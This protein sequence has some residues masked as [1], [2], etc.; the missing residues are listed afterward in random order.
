MEYR[1]S[2]ETDTYEGVLDF[3][4]NS[5]PFGTGRAVLDAAQRALRGIG[6]TP[7]RSCAR[8]RSVLSGEL[9]VPEEHLFFGNG[10]NDIL[11][12]AMLAMRPEKALIPVPAA[13]VYEKTLRAAGCEICYYKKKEENG[14]ALEEDFLELLNEEIDVLI[15]SSPDALTGCLVDRVMLWKI[16]ARCETY[17]IRMIVDESLIEFAENLEKATILADTKRWKMLFILRS[18][19]EMHAIEG[20][21][22]GYAVSSDTEF[23]SRMEELHQFQC[24]PIP[25]Q[26]VAYASLREKQRVKTTREFTAR[27]RRWLEKGLDRIGIEHIISQTNYLLA[28]SEK[29][30]AELLYEK[31]L[32]IR[33]CREEKGLRKGYYRISVRQRGDNQ[34]L[35]DALYE[36]QGI[37]VPKRSST[38]ARGRAERERMVRVSASHTRDSKDASSEK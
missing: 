1:Y 21:P 35:L 22:F 34:K 15:L 17:G 5:N 29:N 28:K 32:L 30:L 37:R 12:T 31:Q 33:D 6:R 8:L 16:L 10:A 9:N 13:G 20:L 25:A 36:I 4:G 11:Y 7:D 24:V 27:E 18:F 14:F 38:V 3:T 26:A 2:G 23:L 19:T